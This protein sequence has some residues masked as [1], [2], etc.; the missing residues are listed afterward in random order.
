MEVYNLPDD[1]PVQPPPQQRA[2]NR[3]SLHGSRRDRGNSGPQPF[4]DAAAPERPATQYSRKSADPPRRP[5][6]QSGHNFYGSGRFAVG[7][8][9]LNSAAPPSPFVGVSTGMAR[10][11]QQN[12]RTLADGDGSR[13]QPRPQPSSQTRSSSLQYRSAAN[14]G[15]AAAP[16]AR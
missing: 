2:S 15:A 13:S 12:D 7:E 4:C 3:G 10:E 9:P 16:T 14:A 1:P 11:R 5:S 6:P 8:S